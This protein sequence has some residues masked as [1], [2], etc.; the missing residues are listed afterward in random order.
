MTTEAP[1]RLLREFDRP[2][3]PPLEELPLP[4]EPPAETLVPNAAPPDGSEAE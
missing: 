2:L 3:L 1:N 4:S